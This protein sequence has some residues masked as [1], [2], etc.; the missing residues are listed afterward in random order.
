MVFIEWGFFLHN[1]ITVQAT[2]QSVKNLRTSFGRYLKTFCLSYDGYSYEGAQSACNYSE[3]ILLSI[4][5]A[6]VSTAL[7]SYS[8]ANYPSGS[9]W[10]DGKYGAQCSILDR[11]VGALSFSRITAPC[12]D[13][14][15][16]LCQI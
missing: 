11:P 10:V 2:C 13:P 7:I 1:L 4:D 5:S 9:V 6:E 8:N 12:I 14:H 3:M 15:L 16:F